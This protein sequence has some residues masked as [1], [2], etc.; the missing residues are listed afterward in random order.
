MSEVTSLRSYL[1]GLGFSVNNT[2]FARFNS[3]L[4][5][6][7]KQVE[8]HTTGIASDVIKWQA[9]ITT[10]FVG[11]SAA[12]IGAVDHVAMADQD[13]RLLGEKMFMDTKHAR[14]MQVA[15]TALGASLDEIAFD[16]ELHSR[17]MQLQKDQQ[18]L[19][20]GLGGDFESTMK[21]IRDVRFEF[22]RLQVELQYGLMGVVSELFKGLGGGN[23]TFL[24][25]LQHLN[26]Y[27]IANL[28]KWQK[29]IADDLVPILKDTWDILKGLSEILGDLA[30]DFTN[31]MA[32]LSGDDTLRS[33]Q[34]NFEKFAGAVEKVVGFIA[35]LVHGLE[36]L[37]KH[38]AILEI[39]GGAAVGAGVGSVVPGVGTAVG[40]VVGALGGTGVAMASAYGQQHATGNSDAARGISTD[41]ADRGRAVALQVSNQTGIPA[42]IIYA[43]LEHET[44]GFTNRGA[45]ELHNFSGINVPGGTGKDYRKFS[46]DEE[47]ANYFANQLKRNYSGALNAKTPDEYAAA[48]QK[49][50]IGAYYTDSYDNY[51]NGLKR[52]INDYDKG[53]SGTIHNTTN[54]GDIHVHGSNLNPDQVAQAV[55]AKINDNA[56]KRTQRQ[57]AELTSVAP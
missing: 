10:A 42:N 53:S 30:N 36:T 26:D 44:N 49:G 45:L 11:V 28:P 24:Q 25:T 51:S 23:T 5:S 14:S 22:T 57:L 16:P 4:A 17:Y 34:F 29:I 48:L 3:A 54:V 18:A 37:E 35:M 1:V 6:A 56:G 33:Q 40:A 31:V 13:F 32:V 8:S 27:F 21:N 52:H 38:T 12:I 46:N 41:L 39:L 9:A 20:G 50:R 47:Y 43:Q 19:T 55:V 15:M 7:A 2:E